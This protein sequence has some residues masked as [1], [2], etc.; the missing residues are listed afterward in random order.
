MY[1]GN[2]LIIDDEENIR[3]MLCDIL[4]DENYLSFPSGEWDEAKKVLL[5]EKVDVVLLDLWLPN[6]GGM[7]ILEILSSDYE[8]VEVII[9]S[10]HG[11]IDMAVKAIKKGAFDFLEKPLSIERILTVVD[12]AIKIKSL[13]E[14]NKSLK[15]TIV[16]DYEIIGESQEIR[17]VKK[18]LK[19]AS[20]SNARVLITGEN[21]SGKEL[22]AR[23]I[24]FQSSRANKPFVEINCAAIPENLIESE[25][26]GHE[27]GAFTGAIAQKKGKF[28]IANT[29]T[30][31]LDEVADMSLATQAKVLRVLEDMRFVRIGGNEVLTT[32]VRVISATN[33]DIPQMI[34][35]GTFREDLFYRLNVVPVHNPSLKERRQDIPLLVEYFLAGFSQE[36]GK[37]KKKIDPKSMEIIQNY[38]WPGNIRELKN[39]I[40]RINV[41]IP[42]NIIK[43]KDVKDLLSLSN[44]SHSRESVQTMQP[45]GINS[46]L[47]LKDAREEFEKQFII[48]KLGE[49][50]YNISAASKSLG[51]ERSNLHK[52]IKQYDIEV[53]RS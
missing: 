13:K 31:F 53:E 47:S 32:D 7:D 43:E 6:V 50:N 26:F 2:V 29:G 18:K 27:K 15:A 12:N 33:K 23:G 30:I 35:E 44:Q 22:I 48:Q 51:I 11:N 49:L 19:A 42:D 39:F 17:D 45:E 10:G 21:G 1:K 5:R 14:E 28:E 52:K 46:S 34:K 9:I 24:H 4:A 38:N 37:E 8:G 20:E 25:L 41:L 16:K 40:E 3:K 36:S